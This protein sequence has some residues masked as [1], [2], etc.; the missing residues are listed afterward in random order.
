MVLVI[1]I[2]EKIKSNLMR[3]IL[4]Y[5]ALTCYTTIYGSKK[6][7]VIFVQNLNCYLYIYKIWLVLF[8]NF[9]INDINEKVIVTCYN[10]NN[11][12]RKHH[13]SCSLLSYELALPPTAG[14]S[15][16]RIQVLVNLLTCMDIL[17][18]NSS[19]FPIG[20]PSSQS[21]I[22]V[23]TST[24]ETKKEYLHINRFASK[25]KNNRTF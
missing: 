1:V 13:D 19:V 12:C 2:Q 18:Q 20:I 24:T 11:A 25:Y 8:I 6:F 21:N 5:G 14:I 10:V 17:V 4:D 3:N 15:V 22:P 23:V 9:S 7:N 16:S